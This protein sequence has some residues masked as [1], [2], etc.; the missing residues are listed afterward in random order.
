MPQPSSR[1]LGIFL[2]AL[3]KLIKGALFVSLAVIVLKLL[4]K[5]IADL[6]MVL[7]TKLHIDAEN[8]FVQ[9]IFMRLD[10][11]DNRLLKEISASAFFMAGMFFTEGA[12]LLFQRRWAEYMAVFETGLFIPFELYEMVWHGTVTKVILLGI[13]IAVVVYLVVLLV[14]KSSEKP[15]ARSGQEKRP[16]AEKTGA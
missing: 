4:D 11:I 10:L 3:F 1:P 14:R 13:N 8:R 12:G 9:D 2:I 5:D 15:A 6:F 16:S 7:I